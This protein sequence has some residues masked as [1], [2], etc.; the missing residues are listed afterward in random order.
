MRRLRPRRLTGSVRRLVT[1]AAAT[2]LAAAAVAT[3]AS[4]AGLT[5]GLGVSTPALDLPPAPTLSSLPVIG[6]L[7]S[8]PTAAIGGLPTAPVQPVQSVVSSI[9]GTPVAT[10]PAGS[11]GGG[12]AANCG[13]GQ[14][15]AG[16]GGGAAAAAGGSAQGSP[17]TAGGPPGTASAERAGAFATVGAATGLSGGGPPPVEQLTPL[18]GISFG[19]APFLWP[20]LLLLD[21]IAAAVAVLVVRKARRPAPGPD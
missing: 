6:P 4:A 11:T 19:H 8:S 20:V 2:S 3:V 18:A 9:L 12:C 10:L 13:P 5:A 7:G 15:V 14:P 17:S 16:D 21:V 1:A